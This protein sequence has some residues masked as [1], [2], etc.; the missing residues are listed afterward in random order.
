M[1]RS[2]ARLDRN[3]IRAMQ[4]GDKINEHGITAERLKDGDIRYSINIMSDGQRV[5]R[6]IG[7]ASEG[8]T[9]E[10]A[11]RAIE[12]LRTKAREDR[13]DLPTGRKLHRTFAEASTEYLERMD[14]SG[15][16]DMKN[17]R[18]H[19]TLYLV[20]HFGTTRL[21]KITTFDLR[22]YRKMR[23][24]QGAKEATIKRGGSVHLNSSARLLSG[25]SADFMPLREAAG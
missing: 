24:G 18:R 7:R 15:G 14:Q 3:A 25:A 19:L 13:L 11:E 21:D 23:G 12:S 1:A 22:R 6:V 4:I 10:Q 5:H 2:F 16:K 8:V 9:R 20:P 17:K